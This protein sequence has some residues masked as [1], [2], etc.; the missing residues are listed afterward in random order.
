MAAVYNTILSC[1][2]PTV[3]IK[4]AALP[5]SAESLV[6]EGSAAPGVAAAESRFGFSRTFAT[7]EIPQFRILWAG[8]VISSLG[9]QMTMV[10]RGY[11]TYDMTGSA[12]MLGVVSISWGIPL[13]FFSLIGGV[14]ADRLRKRDVIVTTQ[15]VLGVTTLLTAVLIHLGFIEIWHLIAIG[16][17]QGLCF[18]FNMPARQAL[19]PEIVGP[20]KI[21]NAVALSQSGMSLSGIVGPALAGSLIAIP[22]VGVA[23]CFYLMASIYA[24]VVWTMLKLPRGEA[25]APK[26]GGRGNVFEELRA[27]LAYVRSSPA[28]LILMLLAF[29]PLIVGQPFQFLF[30]VFQKDVLHTDSVGLGLLFAAVGVGALIGSLGV[31]SLR[32]GANRSR[33]LAVIGVMFGLLLVFFAS[34]DSLPLALVAVALV[35]VANG[36]YM[37]L[38]TSMMMGRTDRAYYG[39]VMSLNMMMFSTMPLV[40]MPVGIMADAV[41]APLTVG[42]SGIIVAAF[43][44]GLALMSSAFRRID[45][46]DPG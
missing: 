25:A 30:P 46:T 44:G 35:G 31:A 32:D 43:V 22:F 34:A 10:A 41:G 36:T 28:L 4:P 39:R 29:V 24:V 11:L 14:M 21:Q 12:T 42:I 18:A 6:A 26:G 13:L 3:A 2:R 19:L 38:N 7:L 40:A 20:G 27:G 16:F 1:E 37:A 17:V 9:V 15:I 8:G 5:A 33:I 23:G 45:A